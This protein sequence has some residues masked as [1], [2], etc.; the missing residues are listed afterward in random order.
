MQVPVSAGAPPSYQVSV[1]AAAAGDLS[2]VSKPD[3]PSAHS[4]LVLAVSVTITCAIFN[5]PSLFFGIPA[6]TLAIVV[7]ISAT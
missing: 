3:Y 4:F 2:G 6:L 5:P 1:A 7:C